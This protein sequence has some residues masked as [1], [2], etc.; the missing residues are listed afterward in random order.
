MVIVK[1]REKI[2]KPSVSQ[3]IWIGPRFAL[4]FL[5]VYGV[6]FKS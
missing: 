5:K 1:L 4:E 6:Y 2:T 3:L